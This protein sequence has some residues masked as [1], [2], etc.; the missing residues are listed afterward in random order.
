MI[1]LKTITEAK[2]L[3]EI[4]NNAC[5]LGAFDTEEPSALVEELRT[6]FSG[7]DFIFI[8]TKDN[9]VRGIIK[10][11]PTTPENQLIVEKC[12]ISRLVTRRGV[13]P[14]H[15]AGII[16]IGLKE[17]PAISKNIVDLCLDFLEKH[18]DVVL[19]EDVYAF[20]KQLRKLG[21]ATHISEKSLLIARRMIPQ[22]RNL[23]R[24]APQEKKVRIP[25]KKESE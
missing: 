19:N 18:P 2:L 13:H 4:K 17:Q 11:I 7:W 10:V 22:I 12:L 16:R 25:R 9:P 15:A 8:P 24:R 21:F 5:V 1:D 6:R 20:P 3:H 23:L 14:Y